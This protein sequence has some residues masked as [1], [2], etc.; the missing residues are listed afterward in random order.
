MTWPRASRCRRRPVSW[1]A[2]RP[3]IWPPDPAAFRPSWCSTP[4][5]D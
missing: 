1:S 2:T 5:P 3:W 4:L